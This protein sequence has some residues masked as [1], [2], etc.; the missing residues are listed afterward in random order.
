MTKPIYTKEMAPVFWGRLDKQEFEPEVRERLYRDAQHY[1]TFSQ[2]KEF[3]P[4][5]WIDN[6]DYILFMH[7]DGEHEAMRR[8]KHEALKRKND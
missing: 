8:E 3:H 5:A 1:E 2:Y 6:L 7:L 4:D